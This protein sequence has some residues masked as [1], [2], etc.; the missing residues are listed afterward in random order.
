MNKIEP[1]YC[2]SLNN[3]SREELKEI[4]EPKYKSYR[5]YGISPIKDL[6]RNITIETQNSINNNEKLE[7]KK[8]YFQSFLSNSVRLHEQRVNNYKIKTPLDVLKEK[9]HILEKKQ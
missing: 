8:I 3:S 6:L 4:V 9:I 1:K 5:E 7:K 2:H